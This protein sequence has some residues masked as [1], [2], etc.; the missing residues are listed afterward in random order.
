MTGERAGDERRLQ[1]GI[2]GTVVAVT[3]SAGRVDHLHRFDFEAEGL[4]NRGAQRIEPLGMRPH[5]QHAVG[6]VRECGRRRERGVH[7]VGP[8]VDRAQRPRRNRRRLRHRVLARPALPHRKALPPVGEELLRDRPS[9]QSVRRMPP[10]GGG[11]ARGGAH[12]QVLV[13]RRHREEAAVA[14]QRRTLEFRPDAGG[15]RGQRS[16]VVR[17]TDDPGMQHVRGTQVMDEARGAGHVLAQAKRLDVRRPH[18]L[19][20]NLG[21]WWRF[22]VDR[23]LEGRVLHQL[24]ESNRAIR[25]PGAH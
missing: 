24:A 8:L 12:R 1:R 21:D 11:D 9:V 22:R 5:G 19:P 14:H 17:R 6:E 20:S 15:K 13:L 7:L 25:L 2:V 4:R 23:Q 10:R 3:A 18:R 16:V